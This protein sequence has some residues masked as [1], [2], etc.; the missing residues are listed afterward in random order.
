MLFVSPSILNKMIVSRLL[1]MHK[2]SS[3]FLIVTVNTKS[4]AEAIS[5]QSSR[6]N[7]SLKLMPTLLSSSSLESNVTKNFNMITLFGENVG[8]LSFY[9]QG[10]GKYPTGESLAQDIVDVLSGDA[11]LS[12]QPSEIKVDNSAL[13]RKYFI[14]TNAKIDASYINNE[15]NVG[16]VKFTI[17]KPISVAGAHELAK[18]ILKED[19]TSFIAGIEE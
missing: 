10:A 12:Y 16:G 7:I 5:P 19:G 4:E 2:G 15:E 1:D 13:M 3:V 9:G 14:R 18:D 17:T 11:A 6:A 8:R